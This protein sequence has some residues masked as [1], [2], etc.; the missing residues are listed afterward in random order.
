MGDFKEL[1]DKYWELGYYTTPVKGKDAFVVGWNKLSKHEELFNQGWDDPGV[2]GVGIC[3]HNVI[4][5]DFDFIESENR[6]LYKE[7]MDVFPPPMVA[8]RGNPHRPPTMFFQ[9]IDNTPA[10]DLNAI[11]VQVL[12]LWGTGN[13]Q[14]TVAAG[15]AHPQFGK[16]ES[17]TQLSLL[18]VAVDEL[19]PFY[20]KYLTRLEEINLKYGSR[21]SATEGKKFW[22]DEIVLKVEP[23][24]SRRNSYKYISRVVFAAMLNGTE[25]SELVSLAIQT[26]DKI[27]GGYRDENGKSFPQKSMFE[28][29]RRKSFKGLTIQQAAEKFVREMTQRNADMYEAA[30]SKDSADLVYKEF[31]SAGFTN[32]VPKSPT[33]DEYKTVR[34]HQVAA[35]YLSAKYD[36]C[37]V[38][39]YRKFAWCKD[40]RYSL[41]EES[42]FKSFV[43]NEIF[44]YPEIVLENEMSTFVNLVKRRYA[45][46]PKELYI[47]DREKVV[48]LNGIYNCL[49]GSFEECDTRKI[50]TLTKLNVS[51]TT[52]D[53]CEVW[54][55][56]ASRVFVNKS[57]EYELKR[58]T[59]FE[60]FAGFALSGSRMD[61]GY[62]QKILWMPGTGYN[63]KG[64]VM[65]IVRLMMH[66]N[67]WSGKHISDFRETDRF[68]WMAFLEKLINYG[69][70]ESDELLKKTRVLNMLTGGDAIDVEIKNGGFFA[71]ENVAKLFL[72]SNHDQIAS[73]FSD[74]IKRRLIFLPFEQ[75]FMEKP[76]L[77]VKDAVQKIGDLEIN[78]LASRMIRRF[79]EVVKREAFTS[80]LDTNKEYTNILKDSDP[81]VEFFEEFLV[82]TKKESDR[83]TIEQL[84]QQFTKYVTKER[85]W[86]KDFKKEKFTMRFKKYAASKGIV[87]R[88]ER[89]ALGRN[90]YYYG[91]RR[92]EFW[93][94]AT[95]K[96]DESTKESFKDR[97]ITR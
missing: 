74:G 34:M 29:P 61:R 23:G 42:I 93:D 39:G 25:E 88:R 1:R 27:N 16:Y 14:Q 84:L 2:T 97:Q 78:Q 50:R 57:G 40:D 79:H 3:L 9:R 20:P 12:G 69:P 49:S 22:N 44:K 56:L 28:C 43:Q 71:Y 96:A 21:I 70:E 66:N 53:K 31:I 41:I 89:G 73:D 32:R 62:L 38:E 26:D 35:S 65:N 18:D 52:D 58:Q 46:D 76:E 67:C 4:A 90:T 36:I 81:V 33:S 17:T 82:I 30:K 11:N 87:G 86:D 6:E 47:F 75:K 24:Q 37:F 63:G 72:S 64:T 8:R 68:S 80:V 95:P 7:I 83:L 85:G 59:L 51:Y 10:K 5:V 94:D 60:E 19:Q 91:L 77:L 92:S 48:F 55:L 45:I 13:C 15:S 54:D